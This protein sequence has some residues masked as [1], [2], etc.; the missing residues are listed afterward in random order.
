MIA[1][2]INRI[3]EKIFTSAAE[4]GDLGGKVDQ[5]PGESCEQFSKRFPL[6]K[7]KWKDRAEEACAGCGKCDGK[8]PK[9]SNPKIQNDDVADLLDEIEDIILWENAGHKIE[10]ELYPFDYAII[11]RY[12]RQAEAEVKAIRE[13]RMQAFIKGWMSQP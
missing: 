8:I 10:W 6:L 3:W 7:G 13:I 9:K 2:A 11:H 1:E 12:W 5:C 4:T